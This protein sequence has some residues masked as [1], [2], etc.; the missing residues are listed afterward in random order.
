MGSLTGG[1]SAGLSWAPSCLQ[2]ERGRENWALSPIMQ[3]D[4][5]APSPGGNCQVPKNSKRGQSHAQGFPVSACVTFVTGPPAQ[6]HDL[7]MPDSRV[8]RHTSLLG[9]KESAAIFFNLHKLQNPE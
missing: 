8:E 9:E 2:S 5:P 4:S 1:S 3:W 6:S 7:A